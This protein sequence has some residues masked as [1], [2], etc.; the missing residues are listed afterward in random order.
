[1]LLAA[2]LAAAA[3]SAQDALYETQGLPAG[4]SIIR[5]YAPGVDIVYLDNGRPVFLYVDRM[6]SMVLEV[7]VPGLV[8]VSDMEINKDTLYFCGNYN[9]DPAVG[10]F[11]VNDMFF[12]S[13]TVEF[14][15]V[16][17]TPVV[18]NGN[19]TFYGAL[20]LT[21]LEV[22][23]D[24]NFVHVLVVMD[25]E[26][27]TPYADD[28]T[29]LI[30][31]RYDGTQWIAEIISETTGVFFFD[32]VAVT[33]N[34]VIVIGDKHGATGDYST[35]WFLPS[36]NFITPLT[37][38]DSLSIYYSP[39]VDYFP[40]SKP[41]IEHIDADMYATAAWGSFEGDTGVVVTIYDNIYTMNTRWFVPDI[42]ESMAFAE[43]KYNPAD[44]TLYLVPDAA[45]SRLTDMVY[46][47][48]LSA[49]E[50]RLS[51]S[52]LPTVYSVDATPP[53]MGAVVS[54]HTAG[55]EFGLW[56]LHKPVCDCDRQIK[57]PSKTNIH[58]IYNFKHPCDEAWVMLPTN[59]EVCPINF[60]TATPFCGEESW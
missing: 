24:G 55:T 28:Y 40:I 32:D 9:G 29:G 59:A 53:Y 8:S 27:G 23:R 16:L 10:Y 57:L 6:G 22:Y 52:D 38:P 21:K 35:F 51:Q 3:V 46:S 7:P 2:L 42:T 60:Y 13:S 41:L 45:K 39:D 12:G 49:V 19:G 54:G 30:D 33:G 47:F 17:Y 50:A 20:T 43:L 34:Y 36:S 18:S 44:N 31:A 14:A 11:D 58:M 37:I 26:F 48:D 4:T 5:E 15:Q 1:M 56:R 25:V